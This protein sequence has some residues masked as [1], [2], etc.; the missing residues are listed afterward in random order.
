MGQKSATTKEQVLMRLEASRGDFLSGEQLADELSIS[1]NAVWKAIRALE[2]KGYQI[3]AVPRRGYRLS[4]KTDILSKE[5]L[6]PLLCAEAASSPFYF[7]DRIPSTNQFAK[8]LAVSQDG[9]QPPFG[10]VVFAREQTAGRGRWQHHFFSPADSGLYFS[11]LLPPAQ[12]SFQD[13]SFVTLFA[14]VAVC[15]SVEEVCG[16]FPQI[17]WVNDLYLH[18][19]KICGILTEAASDFESGALQWMICGIGLN[20][21]VPKGGFPAELPNAGAL[22]MEGNQHV[23]PFS[24][25]RLASAILNRFFEF[26]RRYAG[27]S[28][29]ET[30]SEILRKYKKRCMMPGRN[31]LISTSEQET[32]YPARVIDIDEE[33][34][35]LVQREDRQYVRLSTGHIE[36]C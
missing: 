23:P 10:S 21:T 35:L 15:E 29:E 12:F 26:P 22:Y 6:L 11:I 34:H 8:Q 24:R 13:P 5:G 3:E 25:C 4:Q 9:A 33:G 1:R 7:F 2:K 16:L 36:F 20:L 27:K 14:A 17:K 31:I 30:K 19:K 32:P 18:E 28:A